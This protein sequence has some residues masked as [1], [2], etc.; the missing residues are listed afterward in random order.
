MVKIVNP[1]NAGPF[2][3][4]VAVQQSG[5]TNATNTTA[6]ARKA[7]TVAMPLVV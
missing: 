3:G 5:A 7:R 2:G 6:K 4:C 1:S